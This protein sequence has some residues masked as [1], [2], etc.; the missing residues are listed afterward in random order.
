MKLGR[1]K[2]LRERNPGLDVVVFVAL[3]IGVV[4]QTWVE[5]ARGLHRKGVDDPLFLF[6]GWF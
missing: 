5:V 3:V 4:V 1:L 2:F 6:F